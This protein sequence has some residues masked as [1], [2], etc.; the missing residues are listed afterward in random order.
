MNHENLAQKTIVASRIVST[1]QLFD[2][3]I[4]ARQR[5]IKPSTTETYTYIYEK[6]ISP[7]IGRISPKNVTLFHL[8]QILN[9]MSDSDYA[10]AT[11]ELTATILSSLFSYAC[12]YEFTSVSPA[13]FLDIPKGRSRKE[14]TVFTQWQQNIFLRYTANSPLAA[15][16]HLALYTGMRQGELCALRWQDID[17]RT[18]TLHVQHTM[19]HQSGNAII[20]SPKTSSSIR[21]IPLFPQAVSILEKLARQSSNASNG[22]VFTLN[23]STVRKGQISR[24]IVRILSNIQVDYPDF[25]YFTMHTT[26]HTFATR[27]IEAGMTPKVLQKILGHSSLSVT[28]DT[29]VSVL[30]EEKHRQMK[31]VSNAFALDDEL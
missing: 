5:S 23:G 16:F 15:L 29:Y 25:P 31:L 21:D 7:L 10:S 30:D 19:H 22:F 13:R 6:H 24:E 1:D 4:S 9:S 8:Q 20:T 14:K 27:C 18:E 3:Y 28:M 11:I 17:F 26:R 2:L 12:R